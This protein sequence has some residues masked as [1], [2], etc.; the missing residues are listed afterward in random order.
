[1]VGELPTPL[2]KEILTASFVGQQ[3][4]RRAGLL[5]ELGKERKQLKDS[6]MPSSVSFGF[7]VRPY[8]SDRST[9]E[10]FVSNAAGFVVSSTKDEVI[11]VTNR[12]VF[13]GGRKEGRQ[14]KIMSSKKDING[15]DRDGRVFNPEPI[16][17]SQDHD[18][19]FYSIKTKDHPGVDLQRE[20]PKA[21]LGSARDAY[22]GAEI[23]VFGS[24]LSRERTIRVG[25]V[26]HDQQITLPTQYGK[27]SDLFIQMDA[28]LQPGHS[29]G[30]IVSTETGEVIGM[31]TAILGIQDASGNIIKVTDTATPIDF[32]KEE[33]EKFKQLR[34]EGKTTVSQVPDF[35]YQIPG[36][37][38]LLSV[39]IFY[40][41]PHPLAF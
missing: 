7:F 31:G 4:T 12:H 10:Q 38:F 25:N 20:L 29:G 14:L 21:P 13:E 37:P 2:K 40:N 28:H 24:P 19:A 22:G 3:P 11:V 34:A 39:P 1:M 30:M 18:I 5:A 36:S 33:L 26:T 15:S 35:P 41:S 17:V 27:G 32:V 23:M 9:T 6:L 8:Y 16:H